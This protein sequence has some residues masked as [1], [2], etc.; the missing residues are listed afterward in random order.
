MRTI[1]I[2]AAQGFYGDSILPAV[3]S[4]QRG[5]LDYL[6]FDCLAE[7]TLAILQK[8]RK[9]D[10]S[11]GYTRDIT[12]S[13]PA[14]LPYMKEKG[15]KLLTNA[16]GTNPLGAQQEV[17]RMIQELGI[18][19][20]KVA[21]VTGDDILP[22]LPEFRE[23][24]I[25]LSHMEDGRSIDDVLPR[26]SFAN[27]YLGAWPIVEAL[28]QG[29]DIVITGRTTDSAQFLAPLIYEFGWK[30]DEWDAL[31]QGILMGHLME[32]SGQVT[33]GNFSGDWQSVEEMDRLGFPIAEVEQ[34]GSFVITKAEGTGGLVSIETV[35]EQML[36]EIH[37][38]AAYMTPDVVLDMTQVVLEESGRHRV[39]VRGAKGKPSPDTLKVVMGYPNGYVG[40]AMVGYSWPNALEKA[41]AADRIVR[42]QL[43]RLGWQYEEVQTEFLGYN[44]LH[45]PLSTL[46]EENLNEVY[47]RMAVR[48]PQKEA[49]AKFPRLF[50]PLALSGPPTMSGIGGMT[51]PR[52]LFGMWSCLVPREVVESRVEVS[53]V[54][55]E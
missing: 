11:K 34:S 22:R 49:A 17:L 9:K 32:C 51:A 2:G 29:A 28:R 45:G 44:S 52:E 33:G 10:S 7:L 26:I 35:K 50:P 38:P 25:S 41:K 19:G 6:C 13:M 5:N 40:Q 54:E 48:T 30:K 53:L 24:G 46:P 39:R 20:L 15:F 37:N 42:K 16:G 18:T 31:A 43:E 55:V 47:L 27:A 36:Y 4:V 3:A 14:L 23:K 8:D 1:R 12:S 21:V